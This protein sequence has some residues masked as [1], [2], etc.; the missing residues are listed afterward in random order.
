MLLKGATPAPVAVAML[1]CYFPFFVLNGGD[2][3]AIAGLGGVVVAF[4]VYAARKKRRA[5]QM[6]S[7]ARTVVV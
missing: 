2:D 1:V 7:R 6:K 4:F 5:R 3:L